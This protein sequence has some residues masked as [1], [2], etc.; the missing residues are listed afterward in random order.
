MCVQALRP[1]L[2]YTV[3][4]GRLDA[5]ALLKNEA[6]YGERTKLTLL[7]YLGIPVLQPLDV[8]W[9]SFTIASFIKLK[10]KF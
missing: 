2:G 7:H 9:V 3:G 1:K 5:E 4:D 6:A 8:F 10:R